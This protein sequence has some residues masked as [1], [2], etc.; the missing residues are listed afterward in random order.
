MRYEYFGYP[1]DFIFQYQRAVKTM[2]AEK[3]QAAAKKY[4]QPDQ[5]V[6]LVVGNRSAIQPPLEDLGKT[7]TPVDITIPQP[8]SS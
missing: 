7:V 3:V 5:I 2:T 1:D 8:V 4:L 6:T